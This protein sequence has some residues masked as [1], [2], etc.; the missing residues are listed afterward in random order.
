MIRHPEVKAAVEDR[1]KAGWSA[2]Q[3]AGRMRLKRHPIRASHETIY[4]FAYSK[5][6][7]DEQCY[8]HL[9]N[10]ED[11]IGHVVPAGTT[12]P[13]SSTYKACHTGLNAP[14]S[15]TGNAI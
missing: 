1:L 4:R 2:E 6:G 9:P 11:V 14:S 7:R 15:A 3:I 8:R 13:I 5:D 10:T 12:G